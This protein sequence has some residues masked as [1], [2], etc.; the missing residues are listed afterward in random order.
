MQTGTDR[1][2]VVLVIAAGIIGA[3]QIG[4]VAIAVPLLRDDLGL[5]L[6]AIS[7]IAGAYAL[8]GVVGGLVAGFVVSHFSLRKVVIAGL[9]LIALGNLAGVVVA[10]PTMLIASRVV[11]GIGFLGMVIACPTLLR[12]LVTPRTQQVVFA[13]WASYVPVGGMLMLLVGPVIMQGDWRWLWVFNGALAAAHAL[14]MIAIRPAASEATVAIK[15]P[16]GQDVLAVFRSGVPVLLATAF[17]LYSIQ[18]FA[19]SVFLPAFLI[20]RMDLS[21]AA[22]GILS[23]FVLGASAAGNICAG[24][25]LR[26]G[27]VLWVVFLVVFATIGLAGLVIFSD[28]SPVFLVAA[29]SAVCLG[30]TGLLPSSVIVSMPRF[31]P[32]SQRLALS[33]GLVQHASSIGQLAGPAVLAFWV[34]WRGWSSV[35][36]LFGLIS[37]FGLTTAI[38]LRRVLQ[39]VVPASETGV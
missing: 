39:K 16:T 30:V 8:L 28:R 18:Y 5:S 32:T 4:K 25:V 12:T 38:L 24:F 1:T 7:W 26:R 15:R 34:E 14:A 27:A 9:G 33:M 10:S 17:T 31:A 19:L 20:E 6:V 36:W 29:A 37:L 13:L 2:Q 11:E 21:L 35:P 23:A 22:A 3:C